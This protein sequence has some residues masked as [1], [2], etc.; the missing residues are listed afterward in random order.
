MMAMRKPRFV[1]SAVEAR[2]TLHY[3]KGGWPTYLAILS[4]GGGADVEEIFAPDIA[5]FVFR[6]RD[7]DLADH[8]S[9]LTARQTPE[10]STVL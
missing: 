7:D 6:S 10:R 5:D 2:K 1:K 4:R 9:L 3:I 8:K